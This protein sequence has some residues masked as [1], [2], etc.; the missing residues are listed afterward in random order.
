MKL[1]IDDLVTEKQMSE[2]F[3]IRMDNLRNMRKK[4]PEKYRIMALG[5]YVEDIPYDILTTTIEVVNII[6]N[7]VAIDRLIREH[8]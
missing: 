4:D 6:S 5:F 3:E 7:K 2:R 8:Q 1:N